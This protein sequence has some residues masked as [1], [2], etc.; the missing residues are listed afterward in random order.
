M[1]K[2]ILHLTEQQVDLIYNALE[3]Y[4]AHLV[5]SQGKEKA[6]CFKKLKRS[7]SNLP[8]LDKQG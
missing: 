2:Y 6:E 5:S 3:F 8:T 4:P 7:I 1:E